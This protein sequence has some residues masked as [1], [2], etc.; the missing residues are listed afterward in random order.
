MRIFVCT[1]F[2]ALLLYSANAFPLLKGLRRPSIKRKLIDE[3]ASFSQ[4]SNA[5]PAKIQELAQKL[6]RMTLLSAPAS[7]ANAHMLNGKWETLY[8]SLP[9]PRIDSLKA[10][11]Y[12]A[13]PTPQDAENTLSLDVDCFYQ[14]VNTETN[15]YSNFVDFRT[16]SGG[17]EVTGVMS[18]L[19][20]YSLGG[21]DA[22]ERDK[23]LSI[24]FT[25]IFAN[26]IPGG[27][28]AASESDLMYVLKAS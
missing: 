21:P 4:I 18:T 9:M 24:V 5:N 28:R 8:T 12:N 2:L 16:T 22:E 15:S 7:P 10:L 26:P 17:D 19:G 1:V 13:L 3:C 6:E 27:F 25:D 20:K 23:R 14:L 11:T